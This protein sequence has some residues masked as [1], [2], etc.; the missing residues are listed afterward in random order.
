MIRLKFYFA[1][2][3]FQVGMDTHANDSLLFTLADSS[4]SI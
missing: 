2:V 1:R 4:L 3:R